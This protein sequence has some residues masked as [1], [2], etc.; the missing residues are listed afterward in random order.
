MLWHFKQGDD[1]PIQSRIIIGKAR[2]GLVS[3]IEVRFDKPILT[4]FEIS[5]ERE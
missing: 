3:D 1:G 2:D 5:K 4:M